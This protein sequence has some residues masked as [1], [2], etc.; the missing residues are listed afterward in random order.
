MRL[1][2]FVAAVVLLGACRSGGDR[3]DEIDQVHTV[4]YSI[5]IAGTAGDEVEVAYAGEDG[6]TAKTSFEPARKTWSTTVSTAN[7]DLHVTAKAPG[8]PRL[9]CAIEVDHAEVARV[10]H[11]SACQ[12]EFDLAAT[13]AAPRPS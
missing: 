5:A 2:P 9:T 6:G 1:M 11:E 13:S 3:R 10:D 4:T 7:P 8:R 12:A